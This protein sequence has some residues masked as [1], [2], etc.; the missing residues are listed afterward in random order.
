MPFGVMRIGTDEET[1]PVFLDPGCK[2][3][4]LAINRIE[5]EHAAYAIAEAT[6]FQA[7]CGRPEAAA[8]ADD[9]NRHVCKS[10]G[11]A[12][13]A[14]ERSEVLGRFGHEALQ[15]AGL[16]EFSGAGIG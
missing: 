10:L 1:G 16:P 15:P 7:P 13:I 9:D 11:G 8:V 2:F 5:Q 6:H 3:V 12:R 14:V 4:Q